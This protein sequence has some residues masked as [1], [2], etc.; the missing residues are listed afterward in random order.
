MGVTLPET[1]FSSKEYTGKTRVIVPT[2]ESILAKGKDYYLRVRVLSAEKNISGKLMW[3]DL[4]STEYKEL[5][6]SKVDRN[7]FE[8]SIPAAEITNDFEYCIEVSA[9]KDLVIFPVT[10]PEINRTVVLMK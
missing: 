4:G 6:L 2:D 1:A 3:K 7:V 5:A 9:G 10:S 8:V